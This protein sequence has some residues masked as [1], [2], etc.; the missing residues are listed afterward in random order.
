MRVILPEQH[1]AR[2]IA[3]LTESLLYSKIPTL[4][5]FVWPKSIS[6]P[7][8][9]TI[10]DVNLEAC[11]KHGYEIARITGGGRAY[12]HGNDLSIALS[13][14]MEKRPD[15]TKEMKDLCEAVCGA[16]RELKIPAEIKHRTYKTNE[17][18]TKDGYDVEVNGKK[19]AGY[20]AVWKNNVFLIHGAFVYSQPDCKHWLDLMHAPIG[21]N[22]E[23]AAKE[24]HSYITPLS[25]HTDEPIEHIIISLSKHIAERFDVVK[26]SEN[27]ITFAKNL[28]I[29]LYQSGKWKEGGVSR[30][31]CLYPWGLASGSLIGELSEK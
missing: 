13:K 14:P 28:E 6:V 25:Q 1:T 7:Y 23:Q 18:E 3:A 15:V 19:V 4:A 10:N 30:G 24:M 2:Q 29:E 26:W 8:A 27:D 11:A 12:V 5:F 31:L 9:Q 22:K 16:L 17:K 20:A 21:L